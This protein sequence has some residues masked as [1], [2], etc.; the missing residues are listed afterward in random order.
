MGPRSIS[1]RRSRFAKACIEA[2]GY[3]RI[4]ETSLQVLDLGRFEAAAIKGIEV[5]DALTRSGSR[6]WAPAIGMIGIR[7]LSRGS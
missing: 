6:A 7:T 2:K 4:D 5:F 3:A 1:R